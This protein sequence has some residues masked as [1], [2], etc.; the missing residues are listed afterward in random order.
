MIKEYKSRVIGTYDFLRAALEE[1]NKD[2]KRLKSVGKEADKATLAAVG[3]KNTFPLDFELTEEI[4]PFQLKAFPPRL[5]R[6]RFLA[7]EEL[8]LVEL[9]STSQFRCTEVFALRSP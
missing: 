3:K 2:P 5:S 4:A 8:C 9:Q 1:V 7:I 6:V